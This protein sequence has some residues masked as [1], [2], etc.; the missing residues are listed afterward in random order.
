M[1]NGYAKQ[2]N[3]TSSFSKWVQQTEIDRGNLSGDSTIEHIVQ[4]TTKIEELVHDQ[5]KW[6]VIDI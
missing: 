3:T 5:E 2:R 4:Y 6:W 1:D